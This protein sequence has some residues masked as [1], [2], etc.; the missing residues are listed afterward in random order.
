MSKEL[1][2]HFKKLFDRIGVTIKDSID[3][4]KLLFELIK[5][6]SDRVIDLEI[7]ERLRGD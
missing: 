5:N 2:D 6:L 3:A 4:D 7:K 1:A